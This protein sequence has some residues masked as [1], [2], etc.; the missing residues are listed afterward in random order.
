MGN[1][2]S[3]GGEGFLGTILKVTLPLSTSSCATR[4]AFNDFETPSGGAPDC[5]CRARRAAP[6]TRLYRF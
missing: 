3:V 4:Q 1:Y 5:N 2:E 6:F